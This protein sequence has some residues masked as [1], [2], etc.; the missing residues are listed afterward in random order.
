MLRH[1]EID[2]NP[3][4]LSL[5][6]LQSE[7]LVAAVADADLHT[8]FLPHDH[9]AWVNDAVAISRAAREM[10]A[11]LRPVLIAVLS[12]WD[13]RLRYVAIGGVRVGIDVSGSYR[14]EM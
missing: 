1:P 9:P 5:G 3:V 13:H 10:V 6:A 12:F 7:P 4:G 2:D 11:R 8:G 14:I